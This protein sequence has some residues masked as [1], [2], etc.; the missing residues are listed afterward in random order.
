VKILNLI[1]KDIKLSSKNQMMQYMLAM[2]LIL[3]IVAKIFFLPT[4]DEAPMQLFTTV[5]VPQNIETNLGEFFDIENLGSLEKV[6]SRVE[7]SDQVFGIDYVNNKI[8]VIFQ[9]NEPKEI[10]NFIPGI[11]SIAMHGTEDLGKIE[12]L[13]KEKSNMKELISSLII[14]L[15]LSIS[16]MLIGFNIVLDKESKMMSALSVAPITLWDYL[17]SKIIETF[18]YCVIFS[19]ITHWILLGFTMNIT[20]WLLTVS[21]F[22]LMGIFLGFIIGTFAKN[23]NSA[24]VIIKMLG[25]LLIMLP[26]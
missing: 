6:N 23:E 17:S 8:K 25:F 11:I 16:G 13:G 10:R 24:I 14:M 19:F 3:A 2:P 22:S 15:V 4:I 26:M 7:G 21:A 20:Y 5:N 9:G 1:L 12:S 18:I